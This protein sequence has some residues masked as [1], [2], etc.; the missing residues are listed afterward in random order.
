MATVAGPCWSSARSRARV[1]GVTRGRQT[2]G[3]A[4]TKESEI[5]PWLSWRKRRR[6]I[7]E[8]SFGRRKDGPR[9]WVGRWWCYR[10]YRFHLISTLQNVSS[11]FTFAGTWS[12]RWNSDQY[13]LTQI[14]WYLAAFDYWATVISLP[15]SG[16]RQVQAENTVSRERRMCSIGY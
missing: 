4:A 1:L 9:N 3:L 15:W 16:S 7:E 13:L 2:S 14:Y 6:Q 8:T 12:L 11:S 10:R 5:R